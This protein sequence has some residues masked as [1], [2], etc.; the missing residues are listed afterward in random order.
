MSPTAPGGSCT[1][2]PNSD[3]ASAQLGGGN[4]L[5]LTA[6][7]CARAATHSR[8]HPLFPWK[9]WLGEFRQRKVSP[10]GARQGVG[11]LSPI[12]AF[13]IWME[14]I[15][16]CLLPLLPLC[17][18]IHPSAPF[19]KAPGTLQGQTS[20]KELEGEPRPAGFNCTIKGK[21]PIHRR[22]TR[23]GSCHSYVGNSTIGFFI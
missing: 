20:P 19:G 18:P 6:H 23:K 8:L 14:Q 21:S 22:T 2:I 3:K 5:L 12:P 17:P 7:T 16:G 15:G 1:G 11:S 10:F 9:F 13:P 4:L